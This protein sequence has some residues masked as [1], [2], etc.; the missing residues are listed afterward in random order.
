VA[1]STS[2]AASAAAV[3]AAAMSSTFMVTMLQQPPA[4]RMQRDH[5]TLPD[6][7]TIAE[8]FFMAAHSKRLHWPHGRSI[9]TME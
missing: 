7:G 9:E 4:K 1:A 3:A 2:A 5:G 6:E 8:T